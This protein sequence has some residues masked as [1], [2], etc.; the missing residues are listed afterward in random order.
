MIVKYI[1][2]MLCMLYVHIMLKH[3]PFNKIIIVKVL[4][5]FKFSKY[6]CA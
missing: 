2:F 1:T 3:I 4:S 5:I 6:E